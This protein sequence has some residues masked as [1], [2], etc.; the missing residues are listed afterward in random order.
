VDGTVLDKKKLAQ[1]FASAQRFLV[2]AIWATG[3]SS[4]IPRWS[5]VITNE[6]QLSFVFWTNPG[7]H[8]GGHRF[9]DG[10]PRAARRA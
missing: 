10:G 8:R 1:V 6:K 9:L 5:A 3:N 2:K 4:V 7:L